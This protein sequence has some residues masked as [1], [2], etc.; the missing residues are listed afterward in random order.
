MPIDILLSRTTDT[1]AT[2]DLYLAGYDISCRKRL[3]AAL[4]PLVGAIPVEKMRE[5]NYRVDRDNNK[6]SPAD[7]ARWLDN[8]IAT[9]P[10]SPSPKGK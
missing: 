5:A 10:S 7:S 2:R 4:K 6:Q 1:P 8:A 3:V 9:M